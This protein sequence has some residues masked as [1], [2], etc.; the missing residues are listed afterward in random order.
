MVIL[1]KKSLMN[2][3]IK[4]VTKFV[5][6]YLQEKL[7]TKSCLREKLFQG[8]DWLFGEIK[9]RDEVMNSYTQYDSIL[10]M[11]KSYLLGVYSGFF[12]YSRACVVVIGHDNWTQNP[13]GIIDS[14]EK[15]GKL[16][17]FEL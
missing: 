7:F 6:I 3:I 9:V 2:E 10:E 16:L 14:L 5:N 1:V 12:N 15:L 13:E 4:V 8:N 11:Y 17:F